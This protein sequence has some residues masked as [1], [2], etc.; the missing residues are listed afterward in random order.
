[1][2]KRR[3][4]RR[5]RKGIEVQEGLRSNP[6]SRSQNMRKTDRGKRGMLALSSKKKKKERGGEKKEPEKRSVLKKK[7]SVKM[8]LRKQPA[9]ENHSIKRGG[10]VGAEK[11]ALKVSV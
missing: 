2:K 4:L 7:K 6:T 5:K 3:V 1:M 10:G 8:G 11:G 9:F